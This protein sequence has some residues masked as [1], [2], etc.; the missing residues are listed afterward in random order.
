MSLLRLVRR[1]LSA[2]RWP[3]VTLGGL[4][5][6]LTLVVCALPLDAARTDDQAVRHAVAAAGP[7]V[8]AVVARPPLARPFATADEL[9]NLLGT[10]RSRLGTALQAVTGPGDA[11]VATTDL[12]VADVDLRPRH[13]SRI[14]DLR[15]QTGWQERVD[16]V[17]GRA[18]AA[19]AEP[20]PTS[21]GP[22]P[23]V[24]VA[25][26]EAAA[27]PLG[28]AAGDTVVL[29]GRTAQPIGIRVA[30]TFAP[31][32]EDDEFWAGLTRV[33]RPTHE[34]TDVDDRYLGTALLAPEG[35]PTVVSTVQVDL[36]TRLR[37]PLLPGSIGWAD[38]DPVTTDLAAA[39]AS[40]L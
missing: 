14:L 5:T 19:A 25:L 35:Y 27:G 16:F 12:G 31:T 29:T 23:L 40:G 17:T 38:V 34:P 1:E 8:T 11:A 10:A 6:V 4:L 24:E 28:L 9:A 7:D 22:V 33:L 18:P 15:L 39:S 20:L 37:Y 3:L 21:G 26:A 2:Q 36:A 13:P 32:D 30:G